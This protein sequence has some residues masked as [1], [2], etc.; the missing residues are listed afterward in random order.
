[1]DVLFD[2]MAAVQQSAPEY[3]DPGF[4]VKRVLA[5]GDTVAAHTEL[6]SSKSRPGEG[7]LRQVHLFRFGDDDKIVEYWDITQTVTSDLAN[8][9]NAF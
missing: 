5:D 2:A 6:L 3:P 9:A 1:M 4:V 8:A 7:G